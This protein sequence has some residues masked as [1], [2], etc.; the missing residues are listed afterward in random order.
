VKPAYAGQ[1]ARE[2][3]EAWY[4]ATV[5]TQVFFMHWSGITLQE[6]DKR[7]NKDAFHVGLDPATVLRELDLRLD[8]NETYEFHEDH[9]NKDAALRAKA[10]KQ[11]AKSLLRIKDKRGFKLTIRMYQK[12]VRFNLWSR[13]STL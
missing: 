6:A 4:R 2:I 12:Y 5:T 8:V 7:I 10:W 11:F 1:A 3:V 9:K 13:F